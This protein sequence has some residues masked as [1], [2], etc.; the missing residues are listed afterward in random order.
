MGAS[1]AFVAGAAINMGQIVSQLAGVS[2][3]TFCWWHNWTSTSGTQAPFTEYTSFTPSNYYVDTSGGILRLVVNEDGSKWRRVTTTNSVASLFT[4]GIWYHLAVTFHSTDQG[5]WYI[6]GETTATS[7]SGALPV[8]ALNGNPT[9]LLEFGGYFSSNGITNGK[10]AY[11]N[12]YDREL[13]Q[14][15]IKEVMHKPGSCGP[16]ANV[17]LIE[18]TPIDIINGNTGSITGSVTMDKSGPP[19]VFAPLEQ[20]N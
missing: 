14:A 5:Q 7:L 17:R 9:Q 13:S 3:C 12:A 15:E 20:G 8:D 2:S 16:V 10:M 6:N 19:V 1:S 4:T 11:W 18:D